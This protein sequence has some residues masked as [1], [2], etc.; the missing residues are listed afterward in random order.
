MDSEPHPR[1]LSTVDMSEHDRGVTRDCDL[2]VGNSSSGQIDPDLN[3][4]TSSSSLQTMT[5]AQI[6]E[7]QAKV[8]VASDGDSW[9]DGSAGRVS[10]HQLPL[11]R[12]VEGAEPRPHRPVYKLRGDTSIPVGIQDFS[13]S[14]GGFHRTSR[15]PIAAVTW[16]SLDL[17]TEMED[18][19]SK[20]PPSMVCTLEAPGC[21]QTAARDTSV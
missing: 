6:T 14:T 9:S 20:T 1:P 16:Q 17:P 11:S 5:G 10:V 19:S 15:S 13:A 7:Q 3:S 18:P 4:S 2:A 12:A 21:S 8:S